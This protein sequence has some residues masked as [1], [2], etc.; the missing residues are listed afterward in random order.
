MNGETYYFSERHME[1][2]TSSSFFDG[3]NSEALERKAGDGGTAMAAFTYYS[4]GSGPVLEEYMPFENNESDISIIDLP[5]NVTSKK[6]DNMVYFPNIFKYQNSSGE[7]IYEDSNSLQYEDSDIESI[8]NSVKEHIMNYGGITASIASYDRFYNMDTNSFYCG[9]PS[10][11]TNHAVTIIGWDDNYPVD[12][13]NSEPI[14]KGAYIVLNSWGEEWGEKGVFYVSYDDVWVDFQLR[15]VTSVSDIN[16]D[17]LYQYDTCEMWQQMISNY[18]ANIF[19]SIQDE[20]I[21]E[22]MVGTL[23]EQ[24]CNIYIGLDGELDVNNSDKVQLVAED[25]KLKNGYNTVKLDSPKE[26]TKGQTFSVIIEFSGDGTLGCGMES[27]FEGY[28]SPKSNLNESFMSQ[29]G[30]TWYDIHDE[31]NMRNFSIKVYTQAKEKQWNIDDLKGNAIEEI[32]GYFKFGV[33]T[34]YVENEN[35]INLKILKDDIDLTDKFEIVGNIVVGKGA[36]ISINCPT[37]IEKGEYKVELNLSGY[38]TV[39]KTF[40]VG[41]NLDNYITIQF[42]DVNFYNYIKANVKYLIKNDNNKSLTLTEEEISNITGFTDAEF[43]Q[44]TDIDGIEN[45][46]NLKKLDLSYNYDLVDISNL[47]TLKKLEELSLAE[48]SK[49]EDFSYLKDLTNLKM[50]D[51][52]WTNIKDLDFIANMSNLEYLNLSTSMLNG[53]IDISNIFNLTN[54]KNLILKRCLWLTEE[55]LLEINKLTKLESLDIASCNIKNIDFLK[56]INLKYLYFDNNTYV[57]DEGEITGQNDISDLTPLTKMTNLI[58]LDISNN[59]SITNIE[60]I[61]NLTNLISFHASNLKIKDATILDSEAFKDRDWFAIDLTYNTVEE[62]IKKEI[63]DK[64]V[65]IPKIIQ[66]TCDENSVLYSKE[67]VEL[68]NC[69]WNEYGKSIKISSNKTEDFA[70]INVKSGYAERATYI[71]QI[72]NTEL[73]IKSIS[74]KELPT[75]TTY[76][77]GESLNLTGLKLIV[78]YNDNSIKEIGAGDL[79]SIQ[80][81]DNQTIGKQTITVGYEKNATISFDIYVKENIMVLNDISLKISEQFDLSNYALQID[82]EMKNATYIIEDESIAK[83]ENKIVTGLN[84]GKTNIKISS[85]NGENTN[86]YTIPINVKSNIH[87]GTEENPY[88]ISTVE[89]FNNMRDDFEGYYKLANDIDLSEIENFEPI[90][91]VMDPFK[92]TFDGNGYEIS[93]LK[94]D[95]KIKDWEGIGL[96]GAAENAEIK[97]LGIVKSQINVENITGED[98]LGGT[99]GAIVGKAESTVITNVYS[100]AD[101][102]G[103]VMSTIGGII[104]NA[105]NVQITN[106]YNRGDIVLEGNIPFAQVVG[107][108][109]G[110]IGGNETKISE[111]YNSGNLKNNIYTVGGIVGELSEGLIQ[112]VYNIGNIEAVSNAGGIIGCCYWGDIKIKR[113]YNTGTL[114]VKEHVDIPQTISGGII[115]TIY[116]KVAMSE[117]YYSNKDIEEN[118][119]INGNEEDSVIEKVEYKTIEELKSGILFEDSEDIWIYENNKLPRLK[120]IKEIVSLKLKENTYELIK[121]DNQNYIVGIDVKDKKNGITIEKFIENFEIFEAIIKDIADDQITNNLDI[122]KTGMKVI[123]DDEEEYIII[124]DGDIN[125]DGIADATDAAKLLWY[126]LGK[127]TNMEEY[128]LLQTE[129]NKD[130]IVDATDAAKMLWY[131]LGKISDLGWR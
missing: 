126:S 117:C 110:A 77:R 36:Y 62:T 11:V 84:K 113:A 102:Y 101:I 121:K 42:K 21:T 53:K 130:G 111:C 6:I 61:K 52:G 118:G 129:L 9:D 79:S 98:F 125:S 78:A 68:H 18:A 112:D 28:T 89:E 54:L 72:N 80:G 75:K 123:T 119:S 90:G 120:N 107:G 124:I 33:S 3:E 67:G 22:V 55:E 26:I 25:I 37:G 59:T 27:Y 20:V 17:N 48:N 106:S 88:L 13:F 115:G 116:N 100:E 51:L 114:D 87:L 16:Y 83:I 57:T 47:A 92:G 99:V 14:N 73:S 104:G 19:T 56:D 12:K 64:I 34:S 30:K 49:I 81:Y 122:I 15:G 103:N 94:I 82:P 32:G 43:R 105:Y 38:N 40:S 45:F 74:L 71:M 70:S 93:G 5:T 39:T 24:N 76:M 108:I 91:S 65:E 128:Y 127:I 97:N 58:E 35:K 85:T 95:L 60:V 41:E 44:I 109:A 86:E 4:R 50:L 131:N 66:Q 8:R 1:Y 2:N 69:E 46:Y 63:G 96:F 31:D 7:L 23:N 10:F 29:D